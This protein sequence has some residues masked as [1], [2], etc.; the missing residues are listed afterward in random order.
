MPMPHR[1]IPTHE[2][3]ADHVGAQALLAH[4]GESAIAVRTR[5]RHLQRTNWDL[6]CVVEQSGRLIGT[7]TA[8]ELLALPDEAELGA[9]AA[10]RHGPRVLPG[11]DQEMMASLALLR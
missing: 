9:V 4:P 8:T 2:T 6:V 11:T 1:R 10:R 3:S 7:L 5:I